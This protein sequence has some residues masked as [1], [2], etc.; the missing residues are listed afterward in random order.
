M[1]SGTQKFIKYFNDFY[2]P[3]G[4]YPC[5]KHKKDITWQEI[6]K[7]YDAVLKKNPNHKFD[8]DSVDRELIR[9]EMIDFNIIDPDYSKKESWKRSNKM[10]ML[11]NRLRAVIRPI[12]ESVLKGRKLR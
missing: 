4:I 3:N 11:E 10:V 6:K 9:D 2:G 5:K 7:G 1:N 8:G 12:V